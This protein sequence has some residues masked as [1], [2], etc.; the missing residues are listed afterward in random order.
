MQIFYLFEYQIASWY[1]LFLVFLNVFKILLET[2]TKL[3]I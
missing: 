2:A 1:S 3:Y